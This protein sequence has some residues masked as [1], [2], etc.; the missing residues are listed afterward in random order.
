MANTTLTIDGH[1][2]SCESG[3]TVLQAARRAGIF[4]PSLCQHDQLPAL[5]ACNLCVVEIDNVQDCPTACTTVAAPGMVVHTDSEQLLEL[6]YKALQAMLQHHPDPCIL[7]DARA[8]CEQYQDRNPGAPSPFTNCHQHPALKIG[9][10]SIDV[11]RLNYDQPRECH[12]EKIHSGDPF[13]TRDYNYCIACGLCWRAC[14]QVQQ[15][16]RPQPDTSA[17]AWSARIKALGDNWVEA[18]CNFCGACVD[19]CPGGVLNDRYAKSHV[20][21]AHQPSTICTICPEGCGLKA[22]LSNRKVIATAMPRLDHASRICALGRFA[23]AQ[24]LSAPGR[25]KTPMVRVDGELRPM[26]WDNALAVVAA[27]LEG[28]RDGSFVA[29]IGQTETRENSLIYELFARNVMHGQVIRVFEDARKGTL[30]LLNR[31]LRAGTIRA[32]IVSGDYLDAQALAGFEY[33]AVADFFPS[34]AC[35]VAEAVLPI[36]VLAELEGTVKTFDG[37]T[38]RLKKVVEPPGG[39]RAEWTVLSD[40]ATAMGSD[41]LKS[42]TAN[43]NGSTIPQSLHDPHPR[44]TT[45]DLPQ[46]FRGHLVADI[47]PELRTLGLPHSKVED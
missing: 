1:A 40:L 15:H 10:I 26:E 6:R 25:L 17:P 24:I 8:E 21:S 14:E 46:R 41:L 4:I 20:V 33:L 27:I 30:E 38:V 9:G 13:V 11:G 34:R 47:V 19:I 23:Y 37:R 2:V 12:A 18:G 5:N 36:A 43:V 35:D 22:M 31:E 42:A 44:D 45:K 16:P 39:A 29:V 28:Y 7:C 3:Q 32:G